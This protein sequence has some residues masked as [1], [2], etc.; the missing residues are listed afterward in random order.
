MILRNEFT[1]HSDLETVWAQMLD[2]ES[3]ADCVP[4]ARIEAISPPNGYKGAI[5]VRIGPM[6]VDYKGR[7]TLLDVDEQ[8]RTATI[9]LKGREERGQ[10]SV[11]ATVRNRLEATPGGTRVVAETDLQITGPQAQFGKGVLQ[12]VG[13]RVLVEFSRRLQERIESQGHG[14]SSGGHITGD[15]FGV[16]SP[17][18]PADEA[19]DLGRV[20]AQAMFARTAKAASVLVLLVLGMT[21]LR[22]R[23]KRHGEH[24]FTTRSIS[25]ARLATN[26]VE[27]SHDAGK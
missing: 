6:T 15:S 16:E 23:R 25:A 13:S 8:E 18:G 21:L 4:G 9:L 19:L 27:D 3:V 12:D 7:A 26:A 17:R 11:I 5:R 22:R 1:V 10:G 2:L 24:R 14:G 20:V